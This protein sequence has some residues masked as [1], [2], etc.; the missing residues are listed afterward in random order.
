MPSKSWPINANQSIKQTLI[1]L[2]NV[3]DK[4][5]YYLS[6]ITIYE[7]PELQLL[8]YTTMYYNSPAMIRKITIFDIYVRQKYK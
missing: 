6:V 8:L 2:F 5:H 4:L 3:G 1:L 7:G